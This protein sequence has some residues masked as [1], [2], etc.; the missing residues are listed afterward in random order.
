MRLSG[1]RDDVELVADHTTHARNLQCGIACGP[2]R[3]AVWHLAR[4]HGQIVLDQHVDLPQSLLLQ[5]LGHL[6]LQFLVVE[7]VVRYLDDTWRPLQLGA[8]RVAGGGQRRAAMQRDTPRLDLDQQIVPLAR[9]LHGLIERALGGDLNLFV[10]QVDRRVGQRLVTHT[11]GQRDARS[12]L[13]LGVAG[14]DQRGDVG[15]QRRVDASQSGIDHQMRDV[16]GAFAIRRDRAHAEERV[17]ALGLTILLQA[18]RRLACEDERA[19]ITL[20]DVARMVGDRVD[21]PAVLLGSQTHSAADLIVRAFE[22]L[23]GG[24]P[25]GHIF[26]GCALQEEVARGTNDGGHSV[27]LSQGRYPE[28]FLIVLR[29][30]GAALVERGK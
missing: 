8:R 3:L 6:V 13:S 7:D 19:G 11:Q 26:F 4:E 17:C 24:R 27:I 12:L 21:A 10:G 14:H 1:V 29:F 23:D 16:V 20:A 18:E 2:V 5:R 30:P 22:W 9:S 28:I 15:E 25:V